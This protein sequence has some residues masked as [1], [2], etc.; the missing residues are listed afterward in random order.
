LDRK[1]NV[2]LNVPTTVNDYQLLLDNPNITQLNGIGLGDLGCDDYYYAYSVYQSQLTYKQNAHTWQ[3]D[4]FQGIPVSEWNDPYT[5]IYYSNIVLSGLPSISVTNSSDQQFKD[6]VMGMAFYIRGFEHYLLE[7]IFGQPYKP[8]TANSDLGIPYKLNDN[9]EEKSVRG[10][11]EQTYNQI[12]Q[13]LLQAASLLPNTSTTLNRP[14]KTTAF[15]TLARVYLSM[16]DYTKAGAYADSCL[17]INSTLIDF[18]TLNSALAHP[19]PLTP[20][21][22]KELL[23]PCII[24]SGLFGSASSTCNIDSTLYNSYSNNDLR[25]AI[26]FATN[27]ATN[28]HYFKGEYNGTLAECGS[29]TIDEMFLTRAECFARAGNTQSAMADLNQLLQ[30][31]WLTNTFIPYSATNA[32][33]ALRQILKERRKELIF[34]GIR[35]IDLRRLNQDTRFAVTITRNLNGQIFTLAPNDPKYAYPIPQNEIQ[36]SGMQQNPR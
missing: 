17:R 29:V 8:G 5:I 36:L 9:L 32:D 21:D 35:W 7:E 10:S 33:D 16:Q 34:R 30:K 13:D 22:F 11:V 31:R 15:A 26:Y 27:T 14:T 1:P 2:A 18:N 24:G 4:V 6:N 3:S 12:I 25:K 23:Y 28:T 20:N 19:F